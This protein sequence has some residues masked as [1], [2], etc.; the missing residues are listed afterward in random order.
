MRQSA[1]LH[2]R[3][4]LFCKGKE[5]FIA[6]KLLCSLQVIRNTYSCLPFI[7]ISHTMHSSAHSPETIAIHAG[8]TIDPTTGA[9]AP[10]L[11]LSTTYLRAVDY[12]DTESYIY[13]RYRNPNRLSLE[14]CLLAL[15]QGVEPSGRAYTFASGLAAT[16][17]MFQA[18]RP[19]DHIVIPKEM[20]FGVRAQLHEVFVPWG[21]RV[22]S[23]DMTDLDAVRS[24]IQTDTKLVWVESPSNPTVKLTDLQAVAELAHAVGAVVVCDNTWCPLLQTP[25]TLGCDVV[26]Y[27][28]TKY[29][30]GH[31]DILSG[32]LIFKEHSTYS[33]RVLR[34]QEVGGA[35]CAPY[36]AWMLLRS[37]AT[38]P[39]RMRAHCANALAIAHALE[40]HPALSAVHYPGLVA[41]PFHDLAQK[42]MNSLPGVVKH[43]YGGMMSIE[44]KPTAML[45]ALHAAQKVAGQTKI[46]ARATSLG[47]VES[48]I[49]HR[50]SAEGVNSTTPE[51]LLRLSIGIESAEDLIADLLQALAAVE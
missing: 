17:T 24:A 48:L 29:F 38:L 19:G 10:P 36:D 46:F 50:K 22:E 43:G 27:S 5:Q 30:G 32:A 44:V 11:V 4:M 45:T 28:T 31:S 1:I 42:Q 33:E 18:L 51:G 39:V 25:L 23:V 14:E 16:M 41:N 26:M 9:V 2:V 35:V 49:E 34:L 37:I 7:S 47:G 3:A 6:K 13:S 12:S 21:L 40:N 8:R 15:E 20:Y